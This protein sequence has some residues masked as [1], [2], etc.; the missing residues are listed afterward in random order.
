MHIVVQSAETSFT[1][2]QI[3]C[4]RKTLN[5]CNCYMFTC[6]AHRPVTFHI[7]LVLCEVAIRIYLSDFQHIGNQGP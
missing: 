4:H 2:P 3:L 7:F 5:F 1:E 6:A